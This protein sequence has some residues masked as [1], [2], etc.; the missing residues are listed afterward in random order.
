MS[1]L[2]DLSALDRSLPYRLHRLGRLLRYTLQ[3]FL[4]DLGEPIS[5]EQ[6]FLLFTLRG[7][8][9]Q[10]QTDLADPTLDDRPNITRLIAAMEANGLVRRDA[11]PEDGRRRLVSLTPD[12]EALVDRVLAQARNQRDQMFAGLTPEEID[13]LDRAARI[14]ETNL[15][16][17]NTSPDT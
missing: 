7:R 3:R 9:A 10:A 16:T 4:T 17:L 6:W 14:L 2:H 1:I 13:T 5:P 11:D 15:R 12:G 8:G